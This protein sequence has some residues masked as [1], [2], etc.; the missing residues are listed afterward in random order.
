MEI[1]S[2]KDKLP[3]WLARKILHIGAV[4][5]CAFASL[6][7][8]DLH[9]LA[10]IVFGAVIL[11]T[12]LVYKRY[13]FSDNLGRRSWGIV[14]FAL[15]F[16][17]LLIW[18]HAE[19]KF[20]FT[21]M[22]ILALSD[23]AAAIFGKLFGRKFYNLT[24]DVKTYIG[25]ISFFVGTFIIL[26][27]INSRF[28]LLDYSN[29]QTLLIF[30][31]ISLL[32][33]YSE[34]I[35]S[36]GTDNFTVPIFGFLLLNQLEGY[37]H[38]LGIAELLLLF[39]FFHVF[40]FFAVKK[41]ML[42]VDGA[43]AAALMGFFLFLFGGFLALLPIGFFFLSGS[44]LSKLHGQLSKDAKQGKPRNYIQV[45]CNGGIYSILMIPDFIPHGLHLAFISIAVS[46]SDTWSS[47]I[48]SRFRW[49]HV[50]PLTFK[51][52]PVGVSGAITLPG[53]LA[54]LLGSFSI[55][56][57]VYFAFSVELIT[58]FYVSV[59]GFLGMYLDSILGYLFQAKYKTQSGEIEEDASTESKLISGFKGINNDAV[60]VVSNL[61]IVLLVFF[62]V[63]FA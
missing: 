52:M 19:R 15:A 51:A 20:I 53:T 31:M 5:A 49:R 4:G 33:T 11:L 21:A 24:G 22:L 1:L 3:Q 59:F 13:L 37:H 47:E 63:F 54:G 14:L 25:S 58:A 28:E 40:A 26:M 2:R 55:G 17:L 48:G 50:N 62:W 56:V 10:S 29:I 45:L 41:K 34:G 9:F 30:I 12:F 7:F 23:A 43:I 35:G 18:P 36:G 32:L 39:L 42:S 61:I 38:Y 27:L 46:T 16:C 57:L 6:I 44:L 8:E 60:N